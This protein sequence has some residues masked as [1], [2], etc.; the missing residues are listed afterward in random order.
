M[1]EKKRNAPLTKCYRL[2]KQKKAA[3]CALE[4]KQKVKELEG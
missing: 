2:I 3:M 1:G 4:L